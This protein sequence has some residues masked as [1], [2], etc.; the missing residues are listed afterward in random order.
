[1]PVGPFSLLRESFLSVAE[2]FT[3]QAGPFHC[4]L[5]PLPE[6]SGHLLSVSQ[7][8]ILWMFLCSFDELP[9]LSWGVEGSGR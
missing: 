1:M 2:L 5:P 8:S 6:N 7:I 4:F 3:S 9:S